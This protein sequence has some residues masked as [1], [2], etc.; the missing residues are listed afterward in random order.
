[1]TTYRPFSL[2]SAGPR[3]RK[4]YPLLIVYHVARV[5]TAILTFAL[6]A[7]CLLMMG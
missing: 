5:V 7:A 6:V 3:R 1:M 2:E 4:R